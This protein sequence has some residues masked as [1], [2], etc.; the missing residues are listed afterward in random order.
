MSVGPLSA[1]PGAV[2]VHLLFMVQPARWTSTNGIPALL[3]HCFQHQFVLGVTL[4]AS[5]R[6]TGT[7]DQM[8]HFYSMPSFQFG[9]LKI[10][11]FHWDS[12]GKPPLKLGLFVLKVRN[13]LEFS[14]LGI[15]S[16]WILSVQLMEMSKH[17]PSPTKLKFVPFSWTSS[18]RVFLKP[19]QGLSPVSLPKFTSKYIQKWR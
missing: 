18:Q 16:L 12:V 4:P 19:P 2:S 10:V 7:L 8:L 11:I 14:P 6:R 15:K 13:I 3:F 1:W 9:G 17:N 5:D